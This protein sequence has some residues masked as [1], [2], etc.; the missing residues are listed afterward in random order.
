[1]AGGFQVIAKL[2]ALNEVYINH[3]VNHQSAVTLDVERSGFYQV[4]IFPIIGGNGIAN[5]NVEYTNIVVVTTTTSGT[6]QIA[7]M[8]VC[9]MFA[10]TRRYIYQCK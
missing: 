9:I 2:A 1:M 4:S 5:S 3:T 6:I 8:F 10:Y 7:S